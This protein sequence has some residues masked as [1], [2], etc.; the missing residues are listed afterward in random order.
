[1]ERKTVCVSVEDLKILLDE[2]WRFGT[3]D[4]YEQ[5]G[6]RLLAKR[7]LREEPIVKVRN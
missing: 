3:L 6:I 7:I 4:R 2:T 5:E 1:M